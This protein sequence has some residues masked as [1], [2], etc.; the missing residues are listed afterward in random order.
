LQLPV[1]GDESD[2]EKVTHKDCQVHHQKEQTI[3]NLKLLDT[4]K[5]HKEEFCHQGNIG[6]ARSSVDPLSCL[7]RRGNI[8]AV[9]LLFI[10][11]HI[12][13]KNHSVEKKYVITLK[14]SA[15]T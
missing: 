9:Y 2:N 13:I 11:I 4:R 6:H 7:S 14:I 8:K 1:Q 12:D 3:E 10:N 5:P 15:S